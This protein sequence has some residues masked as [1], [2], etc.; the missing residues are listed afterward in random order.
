MEL[1]KAAN[2]RIEGQALSDG[3]SLHVRKATAAGKITY[4]R[5][6]KDAL[7]G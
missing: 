5:T 2:S 3:V 7:F 1:F 4:V 6:K